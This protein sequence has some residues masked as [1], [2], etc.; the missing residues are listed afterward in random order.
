MER[1]ITRARLRELH[2]SAPQRRDERIAKR[3]GLTLEEARK[4]GL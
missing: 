1:E 4:L 2:D 3:A